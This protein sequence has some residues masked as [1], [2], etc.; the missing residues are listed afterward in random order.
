MCECE[1]EHF[2]RK[3]VE[4]KDPRPYYL[5]PCVCVL[6]YVNIDA[7]TCVI[8]QTSVNLRIFVD[9]AGSGHRL[10]SSVVIHRQRP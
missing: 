5:E 7:C 4:K 2:S 10:F 8:K 9:G 1:R 3:V 6:A